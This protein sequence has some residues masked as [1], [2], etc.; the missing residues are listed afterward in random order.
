MPQDNESVED[1]IGKFNLPALEQ[2]EESS[3]GL[4]VSISLFYK[5]L[6]NED[7]QEFQAFELSKIYLTGL[8]AMAR[9]DN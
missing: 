1:Y 6:V 7:I 2:L 3:K 4:A 8:L 9:P 5:S